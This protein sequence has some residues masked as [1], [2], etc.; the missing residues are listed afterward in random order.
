MRGMRIGTH[1]GDHGR[2]VLVLALFMIFLIPGCL[3]EE[4]GEYPDV[5]RY[6]KIP[7]DAV[8]VTPEADVHPPILHSDEF[9]EP[10]PMPGLVNTKGGEDSPF[11]MPDGD[12]FYFFFTPD[13]SVPPEKQVIDDVTGIYV[14]HKV[15]GT[16]SEAERVWLQDPGKLSLDGAQTIIG[17][18]MWFACARE[19][20]EGLQWF[21]AERVDGEWTNWKHA[22]DRMLELEVGEL[23]FVGDDLYFHSGRD[24]GKGAYDIWMMS[25]DGDDWTTPVNLENVNTEQN[26]GWPYLTPDGGELWFTRQHMGAPSIWRSYKSNGAWQEPELIVETFAAEPT[27]DSEGNLYFAHHFFKDDVMI[28]AD[29]YVCYRK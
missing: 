27:L 10:V 4:P 9:E 14:S 25:R 22:G 16:W 24:G 13:V 1:N 19:G 28:E 17:N 21:T 6:E 23:H 8:K 3:E 11:I 7:R 29:I 15:N 5:T 26:E 20:Y 12:T 2:I 18:T